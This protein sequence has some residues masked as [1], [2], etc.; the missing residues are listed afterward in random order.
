MITYKNR[1]YKYAIIIIIS[2]YSFKA[3]AQILDVS[4]LNELSGCGSW[5]WAKSCQMVISYYGNEVYLCDVLEFAR[6]NDPYRFGNDNCCVSPDSCCETG[7]VSANK[8]ILENWSIDNTLIYRSMT[9]QEIQNN[10]QNNRPLMIHVFREDW[11][12]GHTMVAYGLDGN[13]IF[14]QNPGNGSEIRDY[15]D[16]ITPDYPDDKYWRYTNRMN[17]S[18]TSCLL[19]LHIIGTLNSSNSTFKAVNEIQANCQI[20]NNSNIE[21]ECQN[22]ILLGS[23]FEIQIGSSIDINAGSNLSCP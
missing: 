1:I 12:G 21:L 14:I 4:Y 10:F 5:C 3:N 9:I 13:D 19:S 8:T 16:L 20:T 17:T 23:G 6:T 15:D 18:S 22:D 2:I 7:F 11:S